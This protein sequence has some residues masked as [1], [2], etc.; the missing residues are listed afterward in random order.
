MEDGH[1]LLQKAYEAILNS[2]YE[3]AEAWFE[4]A[5]AEEP[6]NADYHYRLSITFA[7]SNKLNKAVLHAAKAVELDASREDYRLHLET[8]QSRELL[9]EAERT[10]DGT[11]AKAYLAVELLK[12]AVALDPLNTEA[13]LLLS[14]AADA[15]G[16]YALALQSVQEALRLDPA[17]EAA[18]TLLPKAQRKLSQ[19]LG[20]ES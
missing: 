5:I 6:D 12:R 17:H 9:Y 10:L 1:N 16:E 2:D 7:R 19:Y 15:A 13:Y 18:R 3:Q 4:Q 20:T 8:L 14:V 11:E